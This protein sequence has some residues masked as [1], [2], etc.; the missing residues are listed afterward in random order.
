MGF[1]IGELN[2]KKTML[3]YTVLFMVKKKKTKVTIDKVC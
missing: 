2:L 1:E 3:A